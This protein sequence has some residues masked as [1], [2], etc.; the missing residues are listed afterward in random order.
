M[1]VLIGGLSRDDQMIAPGIFILALIALILYFTCWRLP[2]W[3]I[4]FIIRN[5]AAG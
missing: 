1:G 2:A 4:V 3:L 5:F